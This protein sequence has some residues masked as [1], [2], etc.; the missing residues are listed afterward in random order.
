MLATVPAD[1][2]YKIEKRI[3]KRR[4]FERGGGSGVYLLGAY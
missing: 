2:H 3:E 4:L 1:L